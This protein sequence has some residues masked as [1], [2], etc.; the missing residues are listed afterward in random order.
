[1]YLKVSELADRYR[2]SVDAIYAWVR[3]G[4]IPDSCIL[5]IANSIRIDSDRFET[6]LHAGK[7]HRPRSRRAE[8]QAL[9]R[10]ETASAAGFSEDQHTT[11]QESGR[12][13]HRFMTDA[14]TVS[15]DHPYNPKF[16]EPLR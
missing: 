3:A 2:F 15:S 12:Y 8:T 7:L 11:K 6:L 1:M 16:I 5:R 10:R 14:G 13:Q 9:H 4:L